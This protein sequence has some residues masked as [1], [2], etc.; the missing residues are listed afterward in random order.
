MLYTFQP[1]K[2]TTAAVVCT[3]V[4]PGK[5]QT[6]A[7]SGFCP[8]LHAKGENQLSLPF[9]YSADLSLPPEKAGRMISAHF[10]I[11][12]QLWFVSQHIW[13][14]KFYVAYYKPKEMAMVDFIMSGKHLHCFKHFFQIP[15][16]NRQPQWKTP[17]KLDSARVTQPVTWAG[18]AVGFQGSILLGC[19]A[20]WWMSKAITQS[21]LKV[22][23]KCVHVAVD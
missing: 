14:S 22:L 10:F 20:C 12:W 3:F 2:K 1:S 8:E 21:F 11:Y 23:H 5:S 17:L 18:T 4:L 16:Q 15:Q 7:W 13:L 6:K 19:I 9:W